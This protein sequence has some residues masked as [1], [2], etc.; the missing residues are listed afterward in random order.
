MYDALNITIHTHTHTHTHTKL[1]IR[2][3]DTLT[4]LGRG[5]SMMIIG[6]DDEQLQMLSE[7]ILKMQKVHND[8]CVDNDKNNVISIFAAV[9]EHHSQESLQRLARDNQCTVV[10]AGENRTENESR[11]KL[12]YR[13]FLFDFHLFTLTLLC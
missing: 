13:F 12:I 11:K 6:D 3:I 2:S 4:P 8:K 10:V 1:G 7:D 9:G 5:Q